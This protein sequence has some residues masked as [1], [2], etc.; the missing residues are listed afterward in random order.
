MT[1]LVDSTEVLVSDS[2]SPISFQSAAGGQ[3][4]VWDRYIA[5]DGKRAFHIGNICGTCSFFFERLEGA[6]QSINVEEVVDR[7]NVGVSTMD[8]GWSI[9]SKKSCRLGNTTFS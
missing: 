3:W 1:V 9:R 2:A 4:D 6:N 8:L 5:I 7:L